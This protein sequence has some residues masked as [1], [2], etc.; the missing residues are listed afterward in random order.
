MIFFYNA[1]CFESKI[2]PLVRF[3]IKI[4]TTRQTLN[5]KTYD[6]SVFETKITRR[7][8]FEEKKTFLKSTI[9][10]KKLFLKSTFL[11]TKL[12]LKSKFWKNFEHKKSRFDSISI[13][14]CANFAFLVQFQK[15][16]F[17]RKNIFLKNMILNEKDFV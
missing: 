11:K 1:S 5:Q 3:W 16:Q 10:K 17:W 13:V 6:T 9:L 15:T 2:L 7:V 8:Y 14:K 4:F 12:F